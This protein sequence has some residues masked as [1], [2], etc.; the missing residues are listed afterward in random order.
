MSCVAGKDK[1][2]RYS[3]TESDISIQ[4]IAWMYRLTSKSD[5]NKIV[6]FNLVFFLWLYFFLFQDSNTWEVYKYL[7][8]ISI[9]RLIFKRILYVY[10]GFT[11]LNYFLRLLI[12]SRYIYKWENKV[13]NSRSNKPQLLEVSLRSSKVYK[14]QI[15]IRFTGT[16]H[17][18]KGSNYR[19]LPFGLSP[20]LFLFR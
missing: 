6:I 8:D 15:L 2:N 11:L 9:P 17:W 1:L 13:S 5:A 7:D 12:A 14:E 18:E 16:I 10:R 3:L 19:K 20:S 4:D